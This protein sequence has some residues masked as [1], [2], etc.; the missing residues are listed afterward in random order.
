MVVIIIKFDLVIA[1]HV[2]RIRKN[3]DNI[4]YYLRENIQIKLFQK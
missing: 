3:P 1:E 2:Q 4:L